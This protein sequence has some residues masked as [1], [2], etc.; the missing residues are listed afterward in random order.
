MESA[1]PGRGNAETSRSETARWWAF[2]LLIVSSVF[3]AGCYWMVNGD[4]WWHLKAG[5]LILSEGRIPNVNRFAYTNPDSTWIDLHWFFQVIVAAIYGKYGTAGLVVF[6][7]LVGGATVG[8]LFLMTRRR[9]P[10]VYL[11][12]CWLPFIWI[13]TSRYHVRPE[14]LTHFYLALTLF[15]IDRHIAGKDRY[16]WLLIPIQLLWV[17]SQGLF[18]L[19]FCVLGAFALN[20]LFFGGPKDQRVKMVWCIL[21]ICAVTSLLNPYGWTGALFPLELLG[22]VGGDDRE[23]FQLL[24]GETKGM[25]QFLQNYGLNGV[26]MAPTPRL[27]LIT[28]PVVVCAL[29]WSALSHDKRLVYHCLLLTGFGYLVWNMN[30]NASLYAIVWGYVLVDSLGTIFK[31]WSKT[32]QTQTESG[33]TPSG[34]VAG[35]L[36]LFLAV[37]FM[38]SVVDVVQRNRLDGNHFPVRTAGFGEHFWY[39]H[40]AAR[41]LA[42]L[43][44]IQNIYAHYNGT[45]F[46]GVVIYHG[47]SS[48][49]EK[50]K[51]VFAD[52]R[53][54]ANRLDVLHDFIDVLEQGN[55]GLEKAEVILHKYSETLPV[56]AIKN[57]DL[58]YRP[59]FR[60]ELIASKRWNCV[61][62][63]AEPNI[64][65]GIT[66]FVPSDIVRTHGIPTV[67]AEPIL[68]SP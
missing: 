58:I 27:L 64:Y 44:G 52:A 10:A 11:T 30:R 2:F 32:P 20:E 65:D 29:I 24:A 54:E 41:F 28:A 14:M 25:T 33:F 21:A 19:Q 36:M 63:S 60:D 51:R 3:I 38:S 18:I 68:V 49:A 53:L 31:H 6:K 13:Y 4:I 42:E 55:Q 59:R 62:C 5:E 1:E 43:P 61:Y 35:L 45:G 47:F 26:L 16:L 8:T 17:N 66:I 57:E 56:L 23:F 12:I 9:L 40:D 46:A 67:S 34:F 7:S 50:A 22:K 48:D 37:N 39:N 15:C